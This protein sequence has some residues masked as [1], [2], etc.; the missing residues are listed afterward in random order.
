MNPSP[1]HILAILLGG[2]LG[3]AGLLRGFH[4]AATGTGGDS[5][6]IR[7]QLRAATEENERLRREN[8]SLR[9]IVRQGGELS[10]P[11]EFIDHAEKELGLRF[12]SPPVIRR[13]TREDLRNR[14]SAAIESGMG[15]SGVDDRQVAW[16][17]MGWLGP[18]DD[19][20]SQLTLIRTLG[21]MTW[22]DE[23]TGEGWILVDANLNHPP[24]QAALIGLLVAM[25]GHQHFPPDRD[26]PGDETTRAREALHQGLAA[27]SEARYLAVKARSDGF[28][29]MKQDHEVKQILA[30][31]PAFI[32]GLRRFPKNEGRGFADSIHLRGPEA[33]QQ[34]LLHAP[35]STKA[36]IIPAEPVESPIAVGLPA[37]PEP[38]VLTESAGQ[39][40]LRLWLQSRNAPNAD[41]AIETAWKG[42]R[43][44][45]FPDGESFS[46][47]WDLELDSAASADLIQSMRPGTPSAPSGRNELLDGSDMPDVVGETRHLS[48]IRISPTRLR[49]L[50]TASAATAAKLGG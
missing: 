24:D 20:L 47:V 8:E 25:L 28:M 31:L 16:Q 36:I 3:A 15:P 6:E 42:D 17:L 23:V 39:L 50:N 45:L 38:P 48:I 40:G 14:I 9:A 34:A 19:L 2:A 11:P 33:L 1:G 32:Q 4:L 12:K 18:E 46:L 26:Y 5:T 37:T 10:V 21:E 27:G 49:F 22:L 41:P 29:P 44:A 35:R 43:Y 7:N 30:S 13:S